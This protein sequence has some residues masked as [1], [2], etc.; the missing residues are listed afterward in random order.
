MDA[1]GGRVEGQL[2]DGDRHAAGALVAEAQDPLV[3]GDD[4]EPDLVA[5]RVAED[6]RDAVDVVRGD[7]D[8]TRPAPQVAELLAGAPDRGRVDDRQQLLE[9]LQEHAVEERLVAVLEGGQPDVALEVVRLPAHVLEL[10]AH[11]LLDV[12]HAGRQEAAQGEVLALLVAEG[13]VLVEDRVGEQREA[14][15]DHRGGSGAGAQGVEGRAR[16]AMRVA[17]RRGQ[18]GEG[19][20]SVLRGRRGR[21]P[22]GGSVAMT[23]G[24]LMGVAG[25]RSRCPARIS[26]RRRRWRGRGWRRARTR[27]PGAPWRGCRARASR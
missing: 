22:G 5:R 9:V 20:G 10:E 3:V 7:P 21:P 2:A 25:R 6:L 17:A 24:R 23:N 13:G 27:C 18:G 15:E 11:L 8:P 19:H 16:E 4:D 12:H 26:G 14:T 1:G